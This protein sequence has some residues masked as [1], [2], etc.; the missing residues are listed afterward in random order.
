MAST[1]DRT[2]AALAAGIASGYLMGRTRKA[3][4]A[5]AL[6]TFVV[7]RRFR[8]HPM[9]VA[10]EGIH[11]LKDS[12]PVSKLGGQLGG[13]L[14]QA[15]RTAATTVA[16]R[17]LTSLADTLQ[18]RTAALGGGRQE[19]GSEE[20]EKPDESDEEGSDEGEGKG[21]EEGG[22][23][24]REERRS[25]RSAA[26]SRKAASSGKSGQ[27]AKSEGSD[28]R[29]DTAKKKAGSSGSRSAERR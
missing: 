23:G 4:L 1:N 13:Q 11:K 24:S 22:D 9:G 8:L 27:S 7:G 28:G 3:K 25:A 10:E 26:R 20:P 16:N 17:R 12:A 2:K 5:F 14:L 19:D 15:G 21:S 29:S 6:A 18:S